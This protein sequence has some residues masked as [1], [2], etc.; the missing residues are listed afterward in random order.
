[1]SPQAPLIQVEI[2]DVDRLI[3]SGHCTRLIAPAAHGQLCVMPRHAPL[4]SLLMPGVIRIETAAGEEHLFYV[5][6]GYLE[7]K[8]NKV[9]V[10]AD[11]MLRSHE[12]DRNAALEAREDAEQRLRETH[13]KALA[14]LQ[15]LE[16]AAVHRLKRNAL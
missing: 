6:G 12:I 8:S 1:M 3:H 2:T 10:L 7:V 9:T 4:L 14:Q 11:Q 5:S 16:H 15:V 13:L